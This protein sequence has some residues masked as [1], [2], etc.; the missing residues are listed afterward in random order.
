M[1]HDLAHLFIGTEDGENGLL[2]LFF[3]LY[4]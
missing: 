1:F 2:L 4:F 3:A